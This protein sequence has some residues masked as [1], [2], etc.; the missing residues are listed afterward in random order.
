MK[1][2]LLTKHKNASLRIIFVRILR[3]T[4]ISTTKPPFDILYGTDENIT[5]G[6]TLL[7]LGFCHREYQGEK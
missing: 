6:V 5:V 3:V 7:I 1:Q 4:K 2:I